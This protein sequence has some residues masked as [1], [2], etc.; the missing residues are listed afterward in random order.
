MRSL[1]RRMASGPIALT[2]LVLWASL[3][4]GS[5]WKRR[6]TRQSVRVDIQGLLATTTVEQVYQH[7]E[8]WATEATYGFILPENAVVHD[9]AIWF[10][11][12]RRGAFVYPRATVGPT[13]SWPIA[14]RWPRGEAHLAYRGG[15]RWHLQVLPIP[16]LGTRK[17]QFVFSHLMPVRDGQVVYEYPKVTGPPAVGELDFSARVRCPGGVADL[18]SRTHGMGAQRLRGE[19]R[20]GFRRRPAVAQCISF[21]FTPGAKPPP[22]VTSPGEDGPA[23]FMAEVPWPSLPREKRSPRDL[24]FVLDTSASMVSLKR[25]RTV[26]GRILKALQGDDRFALLTVADDV[27]LWRDGRLMK[28]DARNVEAAR[29]YVGG[30]KP[31]GGTDLA[32]GLR[33][34]DASNTDKTRP[35]WIVVL[36]DADDVVGAKGLTRVDELRRQQRRS[37]LPAENVRL[38]WL[39]FGSRGDPAETS[40]LL[41]GRSWYD[42]HWS[43]RT[44]VADEFLSDLA[45]PRIEDL[46]LR[47]TAEKGVDLTDVAHSPPVRGRPVSVIGRY[48]KPGR[49]TVTVSARV[50]GRQR[51]A[52]SHFSLPRRPASASAA[53]A[54]ETLVKILAHRRC[55]WLWDRL[56]QP[57]ADVETLETLVAVSRAE[58]IATRATALLVPATKRDYARYG[59]D[60]AGTELAAGRRLS[61]ARDEIDKREPDAEIA[62]RIAALK[63]RAAALRA[64][65]KYT[66]AAQTLD[67][68]KDLTPLDFAASLAAAILRD[69]VVIRQAVRL[70]RIGDILRPRTRGGAWQELFQPVGVAGLVPVPGGG[71]PKH[72]G[73]APTPQSPATEEQLCTRVGRADFDN[74]ELKDAIQLIRD[75][76]RLSIQVK[77]AELGVARVH[78]NSR[79]NVSLKN[80]S[81]AQIL[82]AVLDDVSAGK[83][84]ADYYVEDEVLTIST[85]GDLSRRTH[86]RIYDVRDVPAPAEG[87]DRLL[88]AHRQDG[89]D[90]RGRRADVVHADATTLRIG[91][92]CLPSRGAGGAGG[93]AAEDVPAATRRM[94][95][96]ELTHLARSTID[97]MSWRTAGGEVGLIRELNGLLVVTQTARNHRL[98]VDLIRKIRS[99]GAAVPEPPETRIWP[100]H[101]EAMFTPQARPAPWV[102]ALLGR[103]RDGKLTKFSSVVVREVGKRKLA[104]IG[105]IW[106]DTALGGTSRITLIRRGSPAAR[107]LLSA[108][109]GMKQAMTLGPSVILA[110]DETRAVSL[111]R[112][113]IG[114][115]DSAELKKLLAAGRK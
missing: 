78:P 21:A 38:K 5:N 72:V 30:L 112:V 69:F 99:A 97:P 2:A 88:P 87:I 53:W 82:R 74:V 31:S 52:R 27:T 115:A 12:V 35:V 24:V 58:R 65:G 114:E 23:A 110:V 103:V 4:A 16:R 9:L 70:G 25:P 20:L 75:G 101:D 15:G 107:A 83:G 57:R 1:Q 22:I 91:Q 76:A 79:V 10:G 17:V 14:R 3:A 100:P 61:H 84:H 93:E 85:S 81:I 104:R 46:R 18:I 13:T 51:V 67:R 32:A 19:V 39:Y 102:L 42:I 60:P 54:A 34:A 109:P 45:Q 36:T 96:R 59:I 8:H 40:N 68:V 55:R 47:V 98:F 113:G 63:K 111:D 108:R 41:G 105:G 26:L 37:V 11:G 28:V 48:A 71:R 86:T 64:A 77:W 94:L 56:Q 66:D 49:V 62:R 90:W 95:P 33:A 44:D 89:P 92:L 43:G 29:K 50:D 73:L 7:R 106:F 80:A 6:I